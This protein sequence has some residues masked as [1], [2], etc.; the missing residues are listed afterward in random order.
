MTKYILQDL[1]KRYKE[2]LEDDKV[3]V[4]IASSKS[5][6]QKELASAACNQSHSVPEIRISLKPTK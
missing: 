3:I 1:S 5:S 2:S 4:W 6:D